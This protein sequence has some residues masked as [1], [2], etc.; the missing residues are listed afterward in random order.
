[1]QGRQYSDLRWQAFVRKL[2]LGIIYILQYKLLLDVEFSI[3]K[4]KLLLFKAKIY[5]L[6]Q[7]CHNQR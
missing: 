6:Q 4:M 1:M 5:Q 3:E 2:L 7:K